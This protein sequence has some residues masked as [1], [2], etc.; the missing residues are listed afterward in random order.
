[1]T[2]TCTTATMPCS[3]TQTRTPWRAAAG[4][5]SHWYLYGPAVDE[6]LADEKV[7][8]PGHYGDTRWLLADKDGTVRDAIDSTDH[9]KEQHQVRS[10][11]Q[12]H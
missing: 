5:V 9:L 12:H 1:M 3:I 2:M 8:T 10:L 7:T 6:I 4:S 11:R